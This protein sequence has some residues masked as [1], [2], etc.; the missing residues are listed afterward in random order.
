MA[1]GQRVT[2]TG[3]AGRGC[4]L[5]AAL[6][7]IACGGSSAPAKGDSPVDQA[8]AKAGEPS[9][10]QLANAPSLDASTLPGSILF[11]SERDGNLEVYRWRAGSSP[12]RLT[13]DPRSD[14]IA[15]AAP[16]GSGFFRVATVEGEVPEAHREQLYWVPTTGEPVAIGR[17]GRR[18]RAASW[19][20]DRSFAVFE[21]DM[22]DANAGTAGPTPEVFSD[23]WR[24]EPGG[25]LVRLTTTEHGAFEPAVSPDGASIAYVSTQDG[26][27]ELY[28]MGSRG[29]APQRLTDWRRDD[30][31]PRWS[32]D[33]RQLAFLRREQGGERLFLLPPSPGAEP[34][35]LVPTAEG[36]KLGHADH[37]WAP[38]GARLAY[39]V[40]R[41][42]QPPQVVVTELADGR[43][44]VISPDGLRATTPRWSPDGQFVVM[45][46]TTGD[47]A[48]LDLY[49]VRASDGAWARLTEAP[50]PDWLPYWTAR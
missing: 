34:R 20:P 36:E 10:P 5:L 14:F 7:A 27:P 33:G 11:V 35:R 50:A 13:D 19:A 25:S 28:V 23:L 31:A 18:G 30:T 32:P 49:V 22:S 45:T 43:T 29:E 9:S 41:P 26:N 40:H 42:Q 17:E 8:K 6:V 12:Q 38:D 39:T 37:A 24:W 15:D 47:P 16:D 4:G 21:S 3:R 1:L 2:S 46:G 44:R 48:A